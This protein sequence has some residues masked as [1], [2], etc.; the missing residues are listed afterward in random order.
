MSVRSCVFSI[1]G[2]Q[3]LEILS[4]FVWFC[5]IC[6]IYLKS[7]TLEII[8]H[9]AHFIALHLISHPWCLFFM[10]SGLSHLHVISQCFCSSA[11]L[12]LYFSS[13]CSAPFFLIKTKNHKATRLGDRIRGRTWCEW[14]EWWK[15]TSPHS[16]VVFVPNS[17]ATSLLL[18]CCFFEVKTVL[19]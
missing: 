2:L 10:T 19:C 8:L 7:W 9:H 6:E 15:C 14:N 11:F 5:C 17:N 1:Y 4:T 13:L 18:C 3:C 12:L 16:M